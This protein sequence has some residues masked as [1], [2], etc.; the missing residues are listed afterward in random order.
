MRGVWAIHLRV[1]RR[2]LHIRHEEPPFWRRQDVPLRLQ[3]EESIL[4]RRCADLKE[5]GRAADGGEAIPVFQLAGADPVAEVFIEGEVFFHGDSLSCCALRG[6]SGAGW[7]L[8]NEGETV[9]Y[10]LNNFDHFFQY[11]NSI[12]SGA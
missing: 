6:G 4:H 11:T 5:F 2:L 1:H 3:G 7:P 12:Y 10:K 8:G 9:Y